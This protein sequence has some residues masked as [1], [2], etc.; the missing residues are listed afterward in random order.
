MYRRVGMLLV[1]AIALVASSGLRA[2]E[3]KKIVL[4]AGPITGHPKN[5]HEYEKSV[6]LLKHLLDTSPNVRGLRVEAHFQG[7]PKDA[8]TLNDA[9]TIVLITD[10]G[11]RKATDHPLYVGDR[12]QQL[13]RQM[14]RGCGLVMLH[15]TTFNPSQHHDRI[16]EWVGGYFDYETGTAPNKWY[17]SIKTWEGPTLVGTVDHPIA[18]GVKPFRVKEEFYYNIR[19][20]TDDTRVKPILRTRPPGETE[21]K[22]VGWAVERQDGGRGFGCTGGHFYENWWLSD[23]RRLI[24]NAI[25]WSAKVEVPAEGVESKLDEPI[26]AL[27]V[28]GHNH[29]AHDWRRVTQALIAVLEQ[30]PRMVVHVTEQPEDLGTT[31]IVDYDLLVMNYSSWDRPGLSAAAKEGFANYLN[32][33]GGLAVIHFAN[34]SFTDTLPNKESDWREYRTKIVRRV[35][36]HGEGKSGHDAFGPLRVQIADAG[37]GHPITAGLA[38][39]DTLDE[40]YYRQMGD[41]PITPLAVAKS[42]DTKVDEPMA[43]AYEYGKGNVFQ[44][45]L[46]HSDVSVRKAGALIRR[47]SVWAAKREPLSFDPPLELTE[48][49]LFRDGSPWKLEDSMQRAE[50]TSQSSVAPTAPLVAGKFGKALDARVARGVVPGSK[51]FREPPLSVECWAKVHSK[52]GFQILV[53]NETKAS[54]THWEMFAFD[55]TGHFTVYM[56]GMQPD[57]VR[58]TNDIADGQWHHLAMTYEPSRVRLFVDGKQ[59]VDQA[60]ERRDRNAKSV[61]G[62]LAIGS[63]VERSLGCDGL[64]DEVCVSS[65]I[66]DFSRSPDS[67]PASDANGL[68]LWRFDSVSD[69]QKS[70]DES[71]RKSAA[72]VEAVKKK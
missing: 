1:L 8:A 23:Y 5:T 20:R 59:V 35:W 49:V 57:H 31:R 41:L 62:D 3:N 71:P 14:N 72:T 51:V 25:V 67:P 54:A 36:V 42:K 11:D 2:A 44:T 40:L 52:A 34:G 46:G 58:S 64:V 21:D 10:G 12:M 53:A 28:T 48:T 56:P 70:L 17:S 37:K 13:E 68:G 33:G 66:R 24:L 50:Q 15:W 32:R 45:V 16:T 26:R 7:W 19:F 27:I 18:R 61:D 39:F 55:G 47:G 6:I 29:P 30:D 22:T 69:Q 63:L 60:I 43:W 9:D 38:D 4:I 65:G